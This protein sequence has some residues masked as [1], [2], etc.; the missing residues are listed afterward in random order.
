M[1]RDEEIESG[2]ETLRMDAIGDKGSSIG[3]VCREV[4]KRALL[5]KLGAS[6]RDNDLLRITRE[7]NF[8][9]EYFELLYY[10]KFNF[11]Y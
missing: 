1:E 4:A 11:Q 8:F 9:F 10:I 5:Y 7:L 3:K 6:T 2:V